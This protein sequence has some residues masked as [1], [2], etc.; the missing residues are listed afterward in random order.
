MR[1]MIFFVMSLFV[2]PIFADVP[3]VDANGGNALAQPS[4]GIVSVNSPN[5]M[6]MQTSNNAAEITRLQQKIQD[7]QNLLQLQGEELA[8]LKQQQNNVSV[9]VDTNAVPAPDVAM[10]ADNQKDQQAYQVAYQLVQ[11]KQYS[12]AI[13]AMQD[14]LKQYPKGQYAANA[15]YWLAQLS[16]ISGE[17][18]Q[19]RNYYLIVAK[20]YSTS[21][22]APDAMLQIGL[23]AYADA[24]YQE[25]QEWWEKVIKQF[26]QSAAAS[27]AQSHLAGLKQNS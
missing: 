23:L 17:N 3:V 15:N 2:L 4:T 13:P 11:N 6:M 27:A 10:S 21:N 5:P 7:L 24:N 22:K 19:A 1:Y 9:A 18:A 26:P 12:D 16:M 8:K 14:Y 25:A 20:Q